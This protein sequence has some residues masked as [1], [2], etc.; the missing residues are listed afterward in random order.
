MDDQDRDLTS[1]DEKIEDSLYHEI[2]HY[3]NSK[4]YNNFKE[5]Y[6][7]FNNICWDKN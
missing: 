6:D 4:S 7:E 2:G 3:L 1:K 5:V